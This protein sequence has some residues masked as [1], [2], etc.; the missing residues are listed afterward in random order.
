M[1]IKQR[2]IDDKIKLDILFDIKDF[3]T[4]KKL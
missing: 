4:I 3:T 2:K 1:D